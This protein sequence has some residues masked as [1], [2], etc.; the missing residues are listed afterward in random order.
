VDTSAIRSQVLT[1]Y[2]DKAKQDGWDM[3][4]FAEIQKIGEKY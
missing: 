4:L 3:S 2:Q 1:A